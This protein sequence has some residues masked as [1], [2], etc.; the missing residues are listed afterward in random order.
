MNEDKN[1][2]D[3]FFKRKYK[4]AKRTHQGGMIKKSCNLISGQLVLYTVAHNV[5]GWAER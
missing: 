2:Q 1:T 5:I 3:L 4:Y